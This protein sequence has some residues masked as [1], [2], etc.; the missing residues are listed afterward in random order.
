MADELAGDAT[1][2]KLCPVPDGESDDDYINAN[3][4]ESHV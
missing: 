3:H 2:V 4:V 1:R